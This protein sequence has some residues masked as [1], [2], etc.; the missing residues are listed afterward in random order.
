MDFNMDSR[1][2]DW[3]ALALE[4]GLQE[5]MGSDEVGDELRQ[6]GY[7]AESLRDSESV[8]IARI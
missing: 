8:G 4:R 3:F 7:E 2:A 6:L 5:N 1:T